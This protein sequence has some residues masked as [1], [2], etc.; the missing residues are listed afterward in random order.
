[1]RYTDFIGI[2]VQ[3]EAPF[4]DL[5]ESLRVTLDIVDER[6]ELLVAVLGR[7]TRVHGQVLLDVEV[8]A[9]VL[10]EASDEAQLGHET[11]R[12]RPN[13]STIAACCCRRRR[14]RCLL[15]LTILCLRFRSMKEQWLF[16]ISYVY[17]VLLSSNS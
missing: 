14:R 9:H 11:N 13:A 17:L 12:V 6:L 7:E 1:M 16:F 8:G 4:G 3:L 10:A 2:V 15:L 5:L